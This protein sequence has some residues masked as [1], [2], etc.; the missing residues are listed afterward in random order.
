VTLRVLDEL[1]QE[2]REELDAQEQTEAREVSGHQTEGVPEQ[3]PDG[4]TVVPRG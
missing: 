2:S 1:E 3:R 4:E